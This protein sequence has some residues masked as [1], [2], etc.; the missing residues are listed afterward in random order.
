MPVE[1]YQTDPATGEKAWID[2]NHGT[3]VP[4]LVVATRPLKVYTNRLSFFTNDTYGTNMAQNAATGGT[5]VEVHNGIDDVLWTASD[6]AGGGKTTFNSTDQNHT[7]GGSRSVKVD[8]S[9][10]DDVFQFD[11]GS[12]LDC[13]GYVSLTIWIYVDKDWKANDDIIIYG[14]DTGT[15]L[16]IGDAV[17]LQDYFDYGDYD[18]WQKISIPLTDMGALAL[19]TTLDALRVRI[20]AKEGKSPKFYLDDLQF[21]QTGIPL[22]YTITPEKNTW[23][24]ID[25]LMIFYADAYAGT[26][27]DGTMPNIPYNGWFG[28]A[29]LDTGILY[30]RFSQ[31]LQ[32]A[33]GSIKNHGGLMNWSRATVTGCGSDGTN[34]WVSVLIEFPSTIILK[35]EV[36]DYLSLTVSEDLSGL[37]TFRVSAGGFVEVRNGW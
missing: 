19:S 17:G 30:Q 13:T 27:A 7:S 4:G 36:D 32:A 21:E 37:L 33:T 15:S 10:V 1:V 35:P 14:W 5:P 28:V 20:V 26:L 18:T 3:E 24:H 22:A 25:T 31:G 2:H 23:L 34:S 16:Q 9:P 29:S 8:N 6:V 12:D 11:R